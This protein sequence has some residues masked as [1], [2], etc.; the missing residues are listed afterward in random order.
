M[1]EVDSLGDLS[2]E[3]VLQTASTVPRFL[4]VVE[5]LKVFKRRRSV[6]KK[7]YQH[8]FRF[9]EESVPSPPLGMRFPLI[10]HIYLYDREREGFR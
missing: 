7:V 6:R 1:T 5:D 8:L 3:A 9:F 10:R 2:A 4:S